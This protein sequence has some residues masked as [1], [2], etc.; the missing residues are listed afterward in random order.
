MMCLRLILDIGTT[1]TLGVGRT[2]QSTSTAL[3]LT[4]VY[5]STNQYAQNLL[6]FSNVYGHIIKLY[7]KHVFGYK[8]TG[9]HQ[10]H[11]VC[12]LENKYMV[13]EIPYWYIPKYKSLIVVQIILSTKA[14]E[15]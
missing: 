11:S 9:N 1:A 15:S 6:K 7:N 12:Y 4:V 8:L 14:M 13:L 10:F 5:I 2:V 3:I